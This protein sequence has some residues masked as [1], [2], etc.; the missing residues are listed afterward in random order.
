MG[1]KI[2][3]HCGVSWL[4]YSVTDV[5][6]MF[7]AMDDSELFPIPSGE[8]SIAFLDDQTLLNI[9]R[10]FLD[11]SSPTDVITF[12]GDSEMD[13]AGEIC[14]SVERAWNYSEKNNGRLGREITLYLVHG[15]LHLSGLDDKDSAAAARMR[16]GEKTVLEFLKRH[17]KLPNFHR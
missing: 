1:R 5:V 4:R 15:W 6:E 7:T 14:V 11:D 13:F 12:P 2:F 10:D 9:H 16:A 8:L 17:G 3:V